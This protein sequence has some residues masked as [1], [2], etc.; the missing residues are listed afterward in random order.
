MDDQ[1]N[2]GDKILEWD[3]FAI[4]I[5]GEVKGKVKYEDLVVGQPLFRRG[6]RCY[7]S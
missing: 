6:G 2:V 5:L 1:V 4:P 7:W 3:P